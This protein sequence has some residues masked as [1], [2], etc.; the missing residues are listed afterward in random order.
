MGRERSSSEGQGQQ[1]KRGTGRKPGRGW[2]GHV[3]TCTCVLLGSVAQGWGSLHAR[4]FVLFSSNLGDELVSELEIVVAWRFHRL[5][6]E[7]PECELWAAQ[8]SSWL[9]ATPY[10]G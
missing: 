1:V 7:E 6:G 10:L 3:Y 5:G 4:C 9:M 8:L 2:V